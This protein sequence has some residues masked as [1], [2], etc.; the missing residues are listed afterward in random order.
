MAESMAFARKVSLELQRT[1]KDLLENITEVLTRVQAKVGNLGE[2]G[3]QLERELRTIA[4]VDALE[5]HV[6][7]I[8][9]S[10]AKFVILI[11]DLDQGWNN[12]NLSN[13]FLLGVLRAATGI[14]GKSENIFPIIFMREDVYQLLMPLTQ[15]ADK[16]RN[17][18][19]IKW[20]KAQL[21][22]VLNSRINFNRARH[23]MPISQDPFESVFPATIGTSHTDNW[24]IDRTLSRPRELL[25]LARNYTESVPS[26]EPDDSALKQSEIAYSSWKLAD[27]C[28]EFSNQYPGLPEFFQTWKAK[29]YRRPYHLRRGDLD[30]MMLSLLSEAPINHEWFNTIADEIEIPKMISILY[31][32]GL[33][34]DY[35]VGG[36]VGGARTLYSFMGP[37]QPRFD[38]VQIHP[39]FRRA[40]ET[41]ERIRS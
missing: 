31:E 39:C 17:I 23:G 8:A 33:L 32:I 5:H 29:F 4:D 3:L 12:S 14:H 41:V 28:S 7:E 25:Q 16:Y 21:M 11:D 15:H 20:D 40:L 35:I 34:G 38:E 10:G 30:E 37:H 24:L 36:A 6:V 22:S 2:F 13:Q 19:T 9:N 26:Q 1:N 27:L 18:E